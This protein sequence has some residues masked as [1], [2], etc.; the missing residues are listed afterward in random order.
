M[1]VSFP[2]SPITSTLDSAGFRKRATQIIRRVF[3][4]VIVGIVAQEGVT[5]L[6]D[7]HRTSPFE[8]PLFLALF[9]ATPAVLLLMARPAALERMR[10]RA[11]LQLAIDG[12]TISESMRNREP[13][14]LQRSQ[15]TAIT[16]DESGLTLWTANRHVWMNVPR[17]LTDFDRMREVL[18]SWKPIV[19]KKAPNRAMRRVFVMYA[20]FCLMGAV[21]R[22]PDMRITA[23]TLGAFILCTLLIMHEVTRSPHF[24]RGFKIQSSVAMVL[25]MAIEIFIAI[26]PS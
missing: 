22:Y 13:I 8:S 10:Q 26:Q 16:E 18:A 4:I 17:E 12:D 14:V 7:T 20:Y 5:Y 21:N 3:P 2:T 11:S 19:Q 1:N 24:G 15:I 23:A 25:L 9:L 6:L